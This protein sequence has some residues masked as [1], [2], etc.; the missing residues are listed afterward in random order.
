MKLGPSRQ[1]QSLPCSKEI[2]RS[3]VTQRYVELFA[4]KIR[5]NANKIELQFL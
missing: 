4:L 3:F 2:I 1:V 5:F